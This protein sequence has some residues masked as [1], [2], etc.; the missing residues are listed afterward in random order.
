MNKKRKAKV[1]YVTSS[2]R[3]RGEMGKDEDQMPSRGG[4]GAPEKGK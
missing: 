1:C 4:V 2:H 3:G